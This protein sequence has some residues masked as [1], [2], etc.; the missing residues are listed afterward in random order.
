MKAL[1]DA[2]RQLVDSGILNR[3]GIGIESPE[4]IA[5]I[6]PY[7]RKALLEFESRNRDH[8]TLLDHPD[9]HAKYMEEGSPA[10]ENAPRWCESIRQQMYN[11]YVD[12]F[13]A[14]LGTR[15]KN[16]PFSPELD[17][18]LDAY[19]PQG[20]V[21]R[22]ARYEA[23]NR[24]SDHTSGEKASST[25]V[26][27]SY[28]NGSSRPYKLNLVIERG[29][30]NATRTVTLA[31]ID[32]ST[33]R[34]ACELMHDA[35]EKAADLFK[36]VADWPEFNPGTGLSSPN[37]VAEAQR[38][39][40]PAQATSG[41]SIKVTLPEGLIDILREA[42]AIIVNIAPDHAPRNLRL[43]IVDELEGF[44]SLLADESRAA[45]GILA[46]TRELTPQD[47]TAMRAALARIY[48]GRYC[49]NPAE[50]LHDTAMADIA[51]PFALEKYSTT[52][53]E[54]AALHDI[55][56]GRYCANL[57]ERL[58]DADMAEIAKPFV[59]VPDSSGSLTAQAPAAAPPEEKRRYIVLRVA[60]PPSE[61][62]P[63]PAPQ[64]AA[65]AEPKGP[66][67]VG[68]SMHAAVAE[69]L[70]AFRTEGQ[71]VIWQEQS[72]WHDEN[73]ELAAPYS[74]MPLNELAHE[75]DYDVIVDYNYVAIIKRRR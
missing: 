57:A 29:G 17:A 67:T 45:A 61:E 7:M 11:A 10:L 31:D 41:R 51:E 39:E 46:D 68:R 50:R 38:C 27:A 66:A 9:L 49:A 60:P 3:P 14:A 13:L 43:P 44:A 1:Y 62:A 69:T 34:G 40:A 23:A 65:D 25:V 24:F 21:A 8:H 71:R 47:V 73:G 35:R 20:Y 18:V 22:L 53:P 63:T 74:Y 64:Q 30:V 58:C 55:Y 19:D 70:K 32:G 37:A 52:C 56:L 12:I 72:V 28:V 36:D 2:V 16:E 75:L 48:R 59:V 33:L 54:Q 5:S 6:S 26:H 42:A 4:G 15:W